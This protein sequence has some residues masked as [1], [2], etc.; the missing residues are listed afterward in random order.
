MINLTNYVL[1]AQFCCHSYKQGG[2][3]IFVSRDIQFHPIDLKYFNK[4][5]DLEICTLKID[6]HKT[7]LIIICIYRSP[8]GDYKY[9]L[10]QLEAILN[11]LYKVS[12]KLILC[13]DFNI[14]HFESN[15]RKNL[16]ESLLASFN[17]FSTITFP[18]R[19]TINSS[20]LIDNIYIDINNYKFSVY[21]LINS[22]SDLDAQVI[23]LA[24]V[25]NINPKIRYTFT[26]KIDCTSTRSFTE[27]LSHENWDEIFLDEDVDKIFNK[28]LDTY[29]KVFNAN[30]PI[31][32]RKKSI[33]S[34]PWITSGIRISCN[35]K[36]NL[37]VSYINSKDPTHKAQ[38]K[39]Y[40]KILSSVIRAAKKM[41]FDSLIQ[42]STNKVKT[43][44][45][46]VK[47]LNNKNNTNKNITNDTTNNQNIASALNL[48]F[49]SVAD[50]IINNTLKTNCLN[51]DDPLAYLRLKFNQP[52]PAFTLKNTTTYEINKII[53]SMIPKDSHGYDEISARTLKISAPF[54]L[55]P[56]T[57]IIN[58]IVS[59]GTLPERLKFS[60]IKPLHKKGN[61]SDFS[62]YRPI[63]LL[64]HC[65]PVFLPLFPII[66]H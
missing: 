60:E 54:I 56:L 18:T 38:Y 51:N 17:L 24:N 48:Y 29:L 39:D 45:N 11:N 10:N 20:T 19:I 14:N 49:A 62:N 46:I 16:L 7:N 42:Q 31:V 43:T 37:Y 47:S 27:D 28:F 33:K 63:S 44:W 64:T 13:G 59:K 9:F 25:Y 2:V 65:G 26:R 35:I 41:Y 58:K 34:N 8:T 32:I 36:R 40:C 1:G 52:S 22:L 12:T 5:K 4:E 6:L 23:E 30:F 61:V 50:N 66:N 53:Q 15:S 55:S 57:Y 3:S 21:P